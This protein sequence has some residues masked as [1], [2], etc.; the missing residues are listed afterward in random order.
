MSATVLVPDHPFQVLSNVIQNGSVF[1]FPSGVHGC[2][3]HGRIPEAMA[4]HSNTEPVDSHL[5]RLPGLFGEPL[6]ASTKAGPYPP[7]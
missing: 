4:G 7:K 1:P 2:V 5:G 3:T 6:I